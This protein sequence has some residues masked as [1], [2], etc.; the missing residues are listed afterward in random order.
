MLGMIYGRRTMRGA[1]RGYATSEMKPVHQW[2]QPRPYDPK[3]RLFSLGRR[4]IGLEVHDQHS[5]IA[6]LGV[7]KQHGAAFPVALWRQGLGIEW[8]FI[9]VERAILPKYRTIAFFKKL[10][11]QIVAIAGTVESHS[12]SRGI[13]ARGDRVMRLSLI[14]PATYLSRSI[15]DQMKE[16]IKHPFCPFGG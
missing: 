16:F 13:A 1:G 7:A 6:A 8:G 12:Y 14:I 10:P 15:G 3:Q 5:Y 4:L 2:G 11:D 9:P